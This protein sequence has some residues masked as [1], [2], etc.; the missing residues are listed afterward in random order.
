MNTKL[1]PRRWTA[2]AA[3]AATLVVAAHGASAAEP[4]ATQVDVVGQMS[5]HDACPSG[6]AD[7]AEALAGAWDDAAKPSSIAVTFEVQGHSVYGV[8]PQTDS[9]RAL[10]QIRRA[11]H[12]LRCNGGDDAAHTVRFVVQFVDRARDARVVL[13]MAPSQR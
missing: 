12:G 1:T 7:L 6:D 5:L 8:T 13:A 4:A 2:L 10:H 3:I 9:A 11:V